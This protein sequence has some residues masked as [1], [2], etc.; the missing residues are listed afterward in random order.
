MAGGLHIVATGNLFL[1]VLE[2]ALSLAPLMV[3]VAD[4]CFMGYRI[5][6]MCGSG[7]ETSGQI[8]EGPEE[9]GPGAA[10]PQRANSAAVQGVLGRRLEPPIPTSRAVVDLTANL[11]PAFPL[12]CQ[13]RMAHHNANHRHLPKLAFLAQSAFLP[14]MANRS[15]HPVFS[16]SGRHEA[17]W[18]QRIL[19]CLREP[20]AQAMI[21]ALGQSSHPRLAEVVAEVG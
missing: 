5:T 4:I 6:A 17:S 16:T 14:T 13:G 20:S 10:A 18:R 21:S 2:D 9:S 11:G 1:P 19:R 7:M 12:S 8:L 3:G 15:A